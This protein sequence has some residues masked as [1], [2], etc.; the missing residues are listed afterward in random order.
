VR[1]CDA[2]LRALRVCAAG[3]NREPRAGPEASAGI[4]GV[5]ADEISGVR[6]GG[7]ASPARRQGKDVAAGGQRQRLAGADN[8]DDPAVAVGG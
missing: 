8:P 4:A 5:A 3:T 7:G 2:R 1:P 6:V